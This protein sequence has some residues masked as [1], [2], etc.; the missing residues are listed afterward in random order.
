MSWNGSAGADSYIVKRSTTSGSGYTNIATGVTAT[1]FTDT[2]LVNGTTYYYVV[3]ATNV[4]G[5]SPDSTEAS[6]TAGLVATITVN[7][8]GTLNGNGK[9][10]LEAT[11]NSLNEA[12]L[13][14]NIATAFAN[15]AGGV[16]DFEGP[17]FNLLD[18]E[19]V[20]LTYGTS[21]ANSL[22]LTV[23][24]GG[25]IDSNQSNNPGEATSGSNC[26]GLRRRRE[27][28]NIHSQ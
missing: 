25:G 20:V 16:W 21:Q 19:T 27:H 13:A 11:G 6:A 22:V 9:T 2:G 17:N 15:N 3:A 7:T 10:F 4:Y 8:V 24:N 28:P 18:G 26:I 12:T 1:S 23:N 5:L 14:A